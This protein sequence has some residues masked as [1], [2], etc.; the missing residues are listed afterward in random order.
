LL[1]TGVGFSIAAVAVHD[2]ELT[3]NGLD[4]VGGRQRTAAVKKSILLK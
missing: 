3:I 4:Q 1:N 2:F